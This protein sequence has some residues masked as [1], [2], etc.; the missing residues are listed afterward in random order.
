MCYDS[1]IKEMEGVNMTDD[2][3]RVLNRV[4]W[5]KLEHAKG[6]IKDVYYKRG[7]KMVKRSYGERV[8]TYL[9]NK[10]CFSEDGGIRG[11]KVFKCHH[12]GKMVD[13]FGLE[14]WC[15]DFYVP[16]GC[17]CSDCYNNEMGEDL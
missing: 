9:Y 4:R 6:Y 7:G 16:N 11:K 15:C 3:A 14:S 8:D 10:L 5:M 2:M 12:C 17:V 13:Y 1:S